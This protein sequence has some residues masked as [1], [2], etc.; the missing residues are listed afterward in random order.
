MLNPRQPLKKKPAVFLINEMFLL[1]SP[2]SLPH[3][4]VL[5]SLCDVVKSTS[6]TLKMGKL[7]QPESCTFLVHGVNEPLGHTDETDP[8]ELGFGKGAL[9]VVADSKST[10]YFSISQKVRCMPTLIKIQIID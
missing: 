4:E 9:L 5:K 6:V 1:N 2:F 3:Y 7:G 10:R 8:P